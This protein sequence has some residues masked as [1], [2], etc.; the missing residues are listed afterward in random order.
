MPPD[1]PHS[2]VSTPKAPQYETMSGLLLDITPH[3][4]VKNIL[5]IELENQELIT[6]S[7]DKDKAMHLT[8]Q[9]NINVLMSEPPR[10]LTE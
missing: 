8:P 10:L 3:S 7:I 9:Q 6:L 1:T 2:E 4:D 5:I